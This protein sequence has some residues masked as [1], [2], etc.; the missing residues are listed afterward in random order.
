MITDDDGEAK[1][2]TLTATL[3]NKNPLKGVG[4][5]ELKLDPDN[6]N[7]LAIDLNGD[8]VVL[9]SWSR[10]VTLWSWPIQ[11]IFTLTLIPML[12]VFNV[13]SLY[14][15][16]GLYTF[17]TSSNKLLYIFIVFISF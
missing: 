7:I 17:Y 16:V 14:D 12:C 5:A 4:R 9:K 8:C 1:N 2:V 6:K 15:M 13:L 11:N 3:A 10:V